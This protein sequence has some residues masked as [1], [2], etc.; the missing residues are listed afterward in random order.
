MYPSA[1]R[2]EINRYCS[3]LDAMYRSFNCRLLCYERAIRTKGRD[4]M[5]LHCVPVPSELLSETFSRFSATV[6]AFRLKFN[7]VMVI[8]Q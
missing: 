3:A 8:I 7:E 2:A 6:S 4:H 5:Q 1:A